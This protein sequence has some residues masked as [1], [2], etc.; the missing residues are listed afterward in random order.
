MWRIDVLSYPYLLD[1]M[2]GEFGSM[3]ERPWTGF[4][5]CKVEVESTTVM[6]R[7]GMFSAA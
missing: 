4:L 3:F 5:L 7:E 1:T 6:R 2:A